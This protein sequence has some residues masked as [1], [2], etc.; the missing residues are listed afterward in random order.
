[1]INDITFLTDEDGNDTGEWTTEEDEMGQEILEEDMGVKLDFS[2]LDLLNYGGD[3]RVLNNEDDASIMT[4]G[5]ALG[6]E[7]NLID[8]QEDT[9]VPG[10]CQA[11]VAPQNSAMSGADSV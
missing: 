1:M 10:V 4:F 3:E 6:A 7:R 5:S 8:D 11:T 9:E 2:G